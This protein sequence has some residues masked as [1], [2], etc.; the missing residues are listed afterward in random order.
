MVLLQTCA[1]HHADGTK[2]IVL[3]PSS[4]AQCGYSMESDPWGNTRIYTSLL[5]CYVDNKV[6]WMA[7]RFSSLNSCWCDCCTS[8][9][10][11]KMFCLQNDEIFNIGL[12]LKVYS[13]SQP[14][15]V[16]HNVAQTCSYSQWASREILCDR[17]YME[18]GGFTSVVLLLCAFSD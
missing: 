10:T 4:A 5:A 12:K 17:N 1:L 3:T 6:I 13:Q 2:D 18:V 11:L 8:L 9:L 14:D 16:T 15:V 7:E